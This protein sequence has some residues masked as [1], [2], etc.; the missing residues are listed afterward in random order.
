MYVILYLGHSYLILGCVYAFLRKRF[1]NNKL[2]YPFLIFLTILPLTPYIYVKYLTVKYLPELRPAVFA[3]I[4]EQEGGDL[5]PERVSMRVMRRT[6]TDASVF[7]IAPCSSKPGLGR[8]GSYYEVKKGKSG[9]NTVDW[10]DVVYSDCGGNA[11]G[12]TF[13][14]F[15]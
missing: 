12:T 14:P 11:N 6:D 5:T 4:R 3:F 9:W 7:A 13:P 15:R 1:P 10:G 8:W 2:K